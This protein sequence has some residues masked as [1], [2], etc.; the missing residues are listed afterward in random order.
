MFTKLFSAAAIAAL[1]TSPVWPTPCA[2]FVYEDGWSVD[3]S[4]EV[5]WDGVFHEHVGFFKQDAQAGDFI[6]VHVADGSPLPVAEV[7]SDDGTVVY[8]SSGTDITV[9]IL[10]SPAQDGE[11]CYA[12]GNSNF[13]WSSEDAT[14]D[15][16]EDYISWSCTKAA[17]PTPVEPTTEPSDEPSEEPT[18][19]P[20]EEPSEE[21]STPTDDNS[22]TTPYAQPSEEESEA[23]KDYTEVVP[24]EE[25]EEPSEPSTPTPGRSSAPAPSTSPSGTAADRKPN[26]VHHDSSRSSSTVVSS[27]STAHP[28]RTSLAHTG[29]GVEAVS[30]VAALLT[31]LG[32]GVLT[33]AMDRKDDEYDD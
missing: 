33:Y 3:S 9:E 14:P 8:Q 26:A 10:S 5:Q 13:W 32:L 29:A 1:T 19:E 20:S 28:R 12:T 2:E 31:V 17:V 23:P 11:T 22:V 16:A 21:P 15:A 25:K 6:T 27:D 24:N 30:G 4:A 7:L 18:T